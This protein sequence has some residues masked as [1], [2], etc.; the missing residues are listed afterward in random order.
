M[1]I[2]QNSWVEISRSALIHNIKQ[3]RK[4]IGPKVRL[5]V[6]VKSNAYGHGLLEVSK[7][8]QKAREV[9]WLGVVNLEEALALR[10]NQIKKSILVLSYYTLDKNQLSLAIQKNVSLVVYQKEQFEYIDKIAGRLNKKAK[11]HFK[12]DTGTSR[13]GIPSK[14][15]FQCINTLVKCKN[16]FLEGLFTHYATAEEKNQDF[17][18]KQTQEFY[19]LIQELEKIN[20][21]IPLKHAACSAAAL[22]DK[23][24]HFDM[25][26][27]GISLY[28][29]WSLEDY[30]S[31]K[32]KY[33]LQPALTWKTRI[34]QIKNISKGQTI[35]YG[36]TYQAAKNM[37][38][39]VLP[40]GYYE[41]YD[42][43]L[44]N[45]GEVLIRGKRCPIRG[46]VCMNLTM[47]DVSRL[48]NVK[49]SDEVVLVGQQ[50]KEVINAD[51]LAQKINTINYEIVTRINPLI[52][53][54]V[55]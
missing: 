13:L 16:L 17:T 32:V 4:I 27:L 1:S 30:Q 34:I 5:M 51:E 43:R 24:Y 14:K 28:G 33:H 10:K 54:I 15:A 25:I 2:S 41:G 7:I 35:G 53:R 45:R 39:A 26:R 31:I 6:V 37:K 9:D 50:G 55:Q 38:I 19:R 40:V 36:R 8:C 42:R 44:S 48:K 3:F 47:V 52:P 11:V 22:V 20:I 46:R 29:L 21:R 12:I 18:I 23:A 49:V